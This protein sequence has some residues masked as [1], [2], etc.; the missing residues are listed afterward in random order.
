MITRL[1]A[2][3]LLLNNK[4]IQYS[5]DGKSWVD[6]TVGSFH[7]S[8][9]LF[10]S[11]PYYFRERP[12]Y[13]FHQLTLSNIMNE[14]DKDQYIQVLEK[15]TDNT[16]QSFSSLSNFDLNLLKDKSRVFGIWEE[17]K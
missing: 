17:V 14:L 12:E 11:A 6:F 1:E 7:P 13:F 9:V 16:Y 8:T 10:T 4:G 2:C 15:Y 3:E 5:K